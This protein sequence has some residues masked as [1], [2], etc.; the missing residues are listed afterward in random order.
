M[1]L[2]LFQVIK[3]PSEVLI[4]EMKIEEVHML[5]T[6][7]SPE[8]LLNPNGIIKIKG[9]GMVVNKTDATEQIMNWLYA[10]LI[11]PGK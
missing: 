11:N 2:A 9:R 10:Y 4:A 7:N 3:K 5:H 1:I 6:D 8:V